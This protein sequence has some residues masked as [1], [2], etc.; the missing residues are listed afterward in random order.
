MNL[1]RATILNDNGRPRPPGTNYTILNVTAID[2]VGIS[3]VTVDLTPLNQSEAQPL[4]RIEGIDIW[5]ETIKAIRHSFSWMPFYFYKFL[6]GEPKMKEIA[7]IF[8]ILSLIFVLLVVPVSALTTTVSIGD[9]EVMPDSS[10]T[11]P[12]MVNEVTNLGLG[13]VNVTYNPSVVHVTDV[14]SGTGNALTVIAHII[15]NT[16]GFVTI[17]AHDPATPHNDSVIFANVTFKAVGDERSSTALNITARLRNWY[18]PYSDIPHNVT[19]GTFTIKPSAEQPTPTPTPTPSNG[20]GGGYVPTTPMPAG[21]PSVVGKVVK[22]ISRIE[23][24]KPESVTFEGLDVYKISIEADKNVND[25]NVMVEELAKPEEIAEAPGI[26]YAYYNITA[27]NLT[28]VNVTTTIEFKV[29]KSWMA[30]ENI[31]TIR[32]CRYDE[33]WKALPTTKIDEDDA[34]VYFSAETHGFSIFAISGTKKE[35]AAVTPALTTPATPATTI[36]PPATAPTPAPTPA[37]PTPA[38]AHGLTPLFLILIVTAVI[39][40]AGIT[41]I[42]LRRK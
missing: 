5:T 25:V 17:I 11:I 34:Y 10:V 39:V 19:N 4:T 24:G 1:S 13:R 36:T 41:I 21:K 38:P 2:N 7:K 22:I 26:V 3:N 18:Y 9:V 29:S 15:N 8:Y 14:T 35:E 20:G 37:T 42:V 33:E 32:L 12:I 23:A 27:T 6:K 28:D 40:I 31:E 30:D 16:A